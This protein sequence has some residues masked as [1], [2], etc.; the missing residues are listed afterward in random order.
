MGEQDNRPIEE[1][2]EVNRVHRW[3]RQSDPICQQ[4]GGSKPIDRWSTRKSDD[5]EEEGSNQGDTL[6]ARHG[7]GGSIYSWQR[8]E[9]VLGEFDSCMSLFLFLVV[10]I[11][12]RCK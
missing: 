3:S 10:S 8:V 1:K 2:K 12:F 9:S 7:G 6:T 11:F 5:G 4:I